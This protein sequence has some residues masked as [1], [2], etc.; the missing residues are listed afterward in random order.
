M[1]RVVSLFL[2]LLAVFVFT[3]TPLVAGDTKRLDHTPRFSPDGRTVV[4][5]S[6]R[7]GDFSLYQV[8]VDGSGLKRL[9]HG[10][11]QDGEASWFPGGETIVFSRKVGDL[12]SLSRMDA[13]GSKVEQL[14]K[15]RRAL[16]PSV[17]PD[18]AWI[19]FEGREGKNNDLY[20]I[21][22]DD[23]R[24]SRLTVHDENDFGPSWSPDGTRIV[25]SSKRTGNY[26]LWIL[27]L[28]DQSLE[29]ITN[30]QGHEVSPA[31]SPDGGRILFSSIDGDEQTLRVL[32]LSSG[33]SKVVAKNSK[34]DA[35]CAWSPGGDAIAYVVSVKGGTA[36]ATAKATGSGERIISGRP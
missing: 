28:E 20:M 9:T 29:Q 30:D 12:W 27:T 34:H 24:E 4:F 6:N 11:G 15:N 36:I 5:S 32:T 33:K 8:A 21:A 13:S 25:F 23:G 14:Q 17:S 3:A 35:A 10:D 18:G 1:K 7:D 31:W 19:V 2:G 16:S 22:S 26:D